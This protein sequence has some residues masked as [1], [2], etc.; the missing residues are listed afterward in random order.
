MSSTFNHELLLL[1][2]QYRGKSQAEVSE[3]AGLDQGHYSR[4]ERGLLNGEPLQSTIEAIASA[5]RFPI[6][7]FTQDDELSGLPLSVHDV[8]WRKKASVTAGEMKR[9]HAE[10][11]LRVMHLRRLLTSIDIKPDLPLPRVDA[12][13][14]GGAD[15][16]AQLIRRS[17]L[18]PDGPIKNL[19]ALCERAGILVVI[20]NFVENVDGVTMRL[21]D[22]PPVV[23]LN[24]KAPADRMRHSL[25]HELGHL[26]MHSVPTDEMEAEADL[27]AGELL[28]PAAQLRSD[29]IGG[30]V[31]LE[32]LVQL[33]RY[34][35]VSVA[36]LLYRAGAAKLISDNQSSYLW[37]QLSA[38]G[39]RK[40]EPPE[41]QF[42]PEPTR[43]FVHV[44]DLHKSELNYTASDFSKLLRF[45]EDEVTTVYGV[46]RREREKPTLRVIK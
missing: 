15:K 22:V 21:R 14:L 13:E 7:F 39:W 1:A 9:L 32:R 42:P 31:T 28:A 44:L 12:D 36:S 43:L 17:W 6:D 34:W 2:R 33:K 18:I 41:T 19:T 11:N 16:V 10:L 25:A 45:D 46:E 37:R 23:F 27:F 30:R 8:A 4:I 24:S 5:L 20:C 40:T 26:I 35:R 29:I 38:R 3:E